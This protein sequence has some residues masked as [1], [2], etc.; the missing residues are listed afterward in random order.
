MQCKVTFAMRI[1]LVLAVL[2]GCH[3]P[4]KKWKQGRTYDMFSGDFEGDI[5]KGWRDT[6]DLEGHDG[7]GNVGALLW[8]ESFADG[9]ILLGSIA[10]VSGAGCAGFVVGFNSGADTSKTGVANATPAT[11]GGDVGC[12]MSFASDG[13]RGWLL[14]RAHRDRG[15]F[16]RCL[17]TM[18]GLEQAC[19][20]VITALGPVDH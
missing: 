1:L 8:P 20:D 6:R 11:F 12:R 3:A 13:K 5:P 7:F 15:V 4:D 10:A 19:E 17:G 9:E 14:I 18:S 2:A 16:V